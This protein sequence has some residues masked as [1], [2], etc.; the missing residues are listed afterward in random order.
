MTARTAPPRERTDREVNDWIE[1]VLASVATR[2]TGSR[3]RLLTREE[4]IAWTR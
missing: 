3:I 4:G 1:H 2:D